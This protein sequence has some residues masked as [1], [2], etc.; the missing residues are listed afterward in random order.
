MEASHIT[1]PNTKTPEMV[2]NHIRQSN[3]YGI[4]LLVGFNNDIAKYSL[5]TSFEQIADDRNTN[6]IVIFVDHYFNYPHKLM[7]K[8]LITQEPS[9]KA[10]NSQ[11]A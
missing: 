3:L 8:L 4:Y 2:I 7:R 6:K 9:V 11:I 10:R 5:Q 1:I